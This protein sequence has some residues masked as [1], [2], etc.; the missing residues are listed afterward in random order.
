VVKL[1]HAAN[2]IFGKIGRIA[3]KKSDITNYF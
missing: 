2:G 1:Y 3:L